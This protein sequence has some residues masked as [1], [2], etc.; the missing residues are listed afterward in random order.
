L[1]GVSRSLQTFL[2]MLMVVWFARHRHTADEWDGIRYAIFLDR[3]SGIVADHHLLF[4]TLRSGQYIPKWASLRPAHLALATSPAKSTF[5]PLIRIAGQETHRSR[6]MASCGR[7]WQASPSESMRSSS[8][9]VIPSVTMLT[10]TSHTFASSRPHISSTSTPTSPERRRDPPRRLVRTRHGP[11]RG[12]QPVTVR[13]GGRGRLQL[14]TEAFRSRFA[15]LVLFVS[16]LLTAESTTGAAWCMSPTV[17]ALQ[18]HL[19]MLWQD[20]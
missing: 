1:Q 6:P 18:T 11:D 3:P 4:C 8:L 10:S 2:L 13:H 9:S 17:P 7:R 16:R 5:R 19:A 15:V 12:A 14:L 20:A